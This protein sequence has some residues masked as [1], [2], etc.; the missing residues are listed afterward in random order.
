MLVLEGRSPS[1]LSVPCCRVSTVTR[2]T[3][4][5]NP[6]EFPGREGVREGEPDDLGLPMERYTYCN[7]GFAACMGQGPVIEQTDEA[8]ALQALQIAPPPVRGDAGRVAL[9]GEG[10]LPLENGAE[11]IIA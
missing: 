9:L 8:R 11:N 6:R 1:V 3:G 7:R 10:G 4:L 2:Y 5:D